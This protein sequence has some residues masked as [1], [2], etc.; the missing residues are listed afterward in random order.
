M[1]RAGATSTWVVVLSLWGA[2]A[3][4]KTTTKAATTTAKPHAAPAGCADSDEHA[5]WIAPQQPVAGA[6]VKLLGVGDE[7]GSG[8]LAVVQPD[9]QRRALTVA[10]HP[11]LP[12]SLSAELPA[13][14]PGA[15]RVVWTRGDKT[16]ACRAFDVAAHPPKPAARVGAVVWPSTH[17][18]D[19]RYENFFAAWIDLLFDAPAAASL[20]F[21]PLHQALRDGGR[22][23]LANYLGL[24]EDDPK[25]KAAIPATPDC[26]DLP[27]FLRAYFSWKL[28]LPFGF[29]DCDRGTDARPPRCSNFETNEQP[30]SGKDQLAA[31][32]SFLRLVTNHVQSGSA[33]TALA[34]DETDY[35]PVAL[36]RKA[37]RPGTIYADP[38][39]HVML[40]VKWVAQTPE[41]GGLL[42]AVDGQPDT[43]IGRKRFWE[44]TFLFTN[45]TKSAGPG[46]KA[47]RPVVRG[48]DGKLASLPNAVIGTGDDP[49]HAPFSDE[50]GK[51]TGDGFYARMGKLINPQGLD[52]EAAYRETLDALAE[53]LTTRVGSVDNGEKF[54]KEKGGVV[55]PMPDGA[56]IFETTGPWEDYATP[57]RDMRLL[58]AMNVL[59]GLPDKIVKHPDLFRLGGRK[60]AEVRDQITKL[61]A[62]LIPTRGITYTRSD[63]TPWKLTVADLLARRAN[64]EVAYNPND[65]V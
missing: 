27:Y 61:H 41:R 44:G 39:G 31:V 11:G 57:S 62:T 16:V 30:P 53:Q 8:E 25:N 9:G 19:R 10:R 23:V 29:R 60:P 55:I 33:R 5:L 32:R 35:Y 22:N 56:K 63:G 50:Q 21:R 1:R 49:A 7:E 47:F 6:P 43:S 58:I 42:L 36:D 13:A 59:L 17:A 2:A 37:L 54:Q 52:A 26:A 18:W 65:C 20:D 15:Y 64:L 46:F 12:G 14:R 4:A 51:L 45:D 3:A 28:Q 24:R 38:Y 48:A 34:D 40:V